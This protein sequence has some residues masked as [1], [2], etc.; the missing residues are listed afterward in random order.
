MKNYGDVNIVP[1]GEIINA[2][3]EYGT[4]DPSPTTDPG[5]LYFRTDLDALRI[6]NG[7]IWQSLSTGGSGVTSFDAGS[8]GLTPTGP[9]TG[10]VTLAGILNLASGGTNANLTSMAPGGIVYDSGT[11]YTI[12]DV[13][14][15]STFRIS[16]DVTAFFTAG[17]YFAISG[18]TGGTNDGAWT[19]SVNSTYSVPYTTVT[20]TSATLTTGLATQGSAYIGTSLAVSATGKTGQLF[21]SGGVSAPTWLTNDT[22]VDVDGVGTVPLVVGTEFNIFGTANQITTVAMVGPPNGVIVALQNNVITPGSVE[23][24]TTLQ[25]D[26]NTAN[27]FLYSNASSQ[28]VSTAS[29]TNGQLL[30]GSTGAV[31][32]AANITT[33][34]SGIS[35]TNG[36]GSIVL[37]NT[38]VTSITGTGNEITASAS[39]GAVTL[40]ISSTYVGQT[41]I[42]TLGSITTGTWNSSAIDATHGGTGQTSYT[43]GDILYADT[44]SSLAKLAAGTSGYVLTSNGPGVAPSWQSPSSPDFT[45][46]RSGSFTCTN[47]TTSVTFSS[48][49]PTAC[50]GVFV[51]WAYASPDVGWVASYSTTGFTYTNANSGLCFYFALGT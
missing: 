29:P 12:F 49:F 8:T 32:V 31:P 47:G 7:T 46:A 28:I 24:T 4:S 43:V 41:S 22:P 5:R 42:T 20:V 35:V 27:A 48:A 17:V 33:S 15:T 23:V 34:G 2:D 25:V 3:I 39:T 40:S 21:L 1:H 36:A 50:T 51:Q 13:P 16:G 14:T 30:I 38:G 9:T 11:P 26:S 37:A 18:S 6:F 10:V 45:T 44:T 19:V